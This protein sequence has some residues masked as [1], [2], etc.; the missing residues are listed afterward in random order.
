MDRGGA[1]TDLLPG[2]EFALNNSESTATGMTP[3]FMTYGQHPRM[4]ATLDIDT[5]V[6]EVT[7]LLERIQNALQCGRDAA[8]EAQIRMTQQ[9]D[10]SQRPSNF[11]ISDMVY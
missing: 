1:W 8:A 3:F 9:L 2:V 10:A 11:K 6:P 4:P 7:S 5:H